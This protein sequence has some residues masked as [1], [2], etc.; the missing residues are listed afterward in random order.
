MCHAHRGTI[1]I[2]I[3]NVSC[4]VQHWQKCKKHLNV[5]SVAINKIIPLLF[6]DTY[7]PQRYLP[8][9]CSE[10]R[11]REGR[12]EGG[13][14][15]QLLLMGNSLRQI[16]N[17]FKICARICQTSQMI[18]KK[19]RK[20]SCKFL[21]LLVGKYSQAWLEWLPLPPFQWG[22]LLEQT[23]ECVGISGCACQHF[24]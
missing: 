7:N 1:E 10:C 9:G 11:V 6:S 19:R 13:W 24:N 14:Y 3:C 12:G 23:N 4:R 20:N 8:H 21:A 22:F 15:T 2:Y 18:C 17:H 5:I 16:V